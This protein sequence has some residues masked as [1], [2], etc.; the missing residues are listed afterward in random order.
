MLNHKENK[1]IKLPLLYQ[2]NVVF[3][4]FKIVPQVQFGLKLQLLNISATLPIGTL[5]IS[6]KNCNFLPFNF[7]KSLLIRNSTINSKIYIL[8]QNLLRSKLVIKF[9]NRLNKQ[10]SAQLQGAFSG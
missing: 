7:S 10:L 2:K 9:F 6:H 4:F 1:I 8:D 3:N 5:N